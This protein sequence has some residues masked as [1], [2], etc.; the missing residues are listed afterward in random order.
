MTAQALI[1]L[2]VVPR[3]EA[4][5]RRED[6]WE[7]DVLAMGEL[8]T[9]ELP[10]RAN[11]ARSAQSVLQG[12]S[13]DLDRQGVGPDDERRREIERGLA[14]EADR[15]VKSYRALARTRVPSTPDRR[16]TSTGKSS[17]GAGK[18]NASGGKR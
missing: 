5:K 10:D 9:A 14:E 17:S 8:L 4:R 16:R 13:A 6:R 11:E 2:R 1:Q 7:R 18:T 15:D 12:V 3:A